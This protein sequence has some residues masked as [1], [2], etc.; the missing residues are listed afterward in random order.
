MIKYE[1]YKL[2]E[3]FFD[4]DPFNGAHFKGDFQGLKEAIN[5]ILYRKAQEHKDEKLE[6]IN[7]LGKLMPDCMRCGVSRLEM[8]EYGMYEPCEVEGEK[9][10]C[11]NYTVTAKQWKHDQLIKI[12]S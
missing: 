3:E 2:L 10:P 6:M 1:V 8:Q 9:Y 7:Q 11:H 5:E 4:I 12:E